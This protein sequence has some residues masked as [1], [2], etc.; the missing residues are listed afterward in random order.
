MIGFFYFLYFS[1]LSLI[2][3]G[4]NPKI[5]NNITTKKTIVRIESANPIGIQRGEVTHHQ[6][7]SM[8]P[9][10]LRTKNTMNNTP[11]NPMPDE[12]LFDAIIYYIPNLSNKLFLF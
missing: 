12:E 4:E 6:D 1:M 2:A 3:V 7:Q 8:F 9:V 5:I 11:V 10:S